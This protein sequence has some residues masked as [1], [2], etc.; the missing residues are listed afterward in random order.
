METLALGFLIA[1]PINPSPFPF[2]QRDPHRP[3][4]LAAAQAAKASGK[5]LMAGALADPVDGGL[6]VFTPAATTEEVEAFAKAD[7][8]NVAGLI[9]EWSVR[10][11]LVVVE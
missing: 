5:L 1:F 2:P 6:F 9:T 11:W 10:P 7:P 8:Y 3:A 4:H